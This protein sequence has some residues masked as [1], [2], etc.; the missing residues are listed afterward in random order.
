MLTKEEAIK[1][2]ETVHKT[3]VKACAPYKT[4]Y[5]VRIAQ[6]FDPFFTIDATTGL[7]EEFGAMEPGNVAILMDAFGEQQN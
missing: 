6:Q 3:T 5:I 4:G 7:V 1:V 2:V